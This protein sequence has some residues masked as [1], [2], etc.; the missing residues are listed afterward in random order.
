MEPGYHIIFSVE[1]ALHMMKKYQL[2]G[3]TWIYDNRYYI[4]NLTNQDMPI[5]LTA[6]AA[7]TLL[8]SIISFNKD[9][10]FLDPEFVKLYKKSYNIFYRDIK[11]KRILN[12]L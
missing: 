2:D 5:V 4:P 9:R 6:D 11:L 3:Y 10:Y 1:D 12:D 7:K 8:F